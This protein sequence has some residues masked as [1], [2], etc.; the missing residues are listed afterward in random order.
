MDNTFVKD[1]KI[2]STQIDHNAS[3]GI[4]QVLGLNQDNFCEYFKV[5]GC[6]GLTMIPIAK[7]F[8][9]TTK[10]KFKILKQPHWLDIVRVTSSIAKR[11]TARI[12][13]DC[14]IVDSEGNLCAYG[15]QEL[16]AMDSENRHLRMV[17]STL[18][19]SDIVP[20]NS[21]DIE[22]SKLSFEQGKNHL[23]VPVKFSNIDF[24]GHTNNIEYLKIMLDILPA[25]L[26]NKITITGC[27]IHYLRESKMGDYLDIYY[28]ILDD[29]IQFIAYKDNEIINKT[30]VEF[31]M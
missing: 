10:S 25:D 19:P 7:C 20:A 3:L 4:L 23:V 30:V 22:F 28:T 12:E 17:D 16:C 11:S 31:L 5:L 8:F 21:N 14:S 18:F 2:A 24:F 15:K 13:C 26:V 6:D 29:K 1:Y 9:V 27:E